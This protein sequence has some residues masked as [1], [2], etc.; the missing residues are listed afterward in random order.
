MSLQRPIALCVILSCLLCPEPFSR[1]LAADEAET[2]KTAP[3]PNDAPPPDRIEELKK[4]ADEL[5]DAIEQQEETIERLSEAHD[6]IANVRNEFESIQV[7]RENAD[8]T[9][10]RAVQ[11]LRKSRA[12]QTEDDEA[13]EALRTRTEEDYQKAKIRL[14]L[15]EISLWQHVEELRAHKKRLQDEEI[16]IRERESVLQAL[17]KTIHILKEFL[18]DEPERKLPCSKE[19]AKPEDKKDKEPEQEETEQEDTSSSLESE[20]FVNHLAQGAE[21]LRRQVD[22]FF[23][24][25]LVTVIPEAE[26]LGHFSRQAMGDGNDS[27][28]FNGSECVLDYRFDHPARFPL[29]TYGFNGEHLERP[30]LLIYEG[31][32]LA[33]RPDGRYQVRFTAGTPPMPVAFQ[34]QFQLLDQCTGQPYTLTLPPITLPT[35]SK[36]AISTVSHPPR[37]V[38]K[39][40]QT[41]H[42]EGYLPIL[43]NMYDFANVAVIRRTG[44]ARFGYGVRVP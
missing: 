9:R 16:L 37:A 12:S 38:F 6:F 41:I 40:L 7:A 2:A 10:D 24:Q 13:F 20:S 14:E 22:P 15:E 31:M 1:F 26:H 32:R 36:H 27:G 21:F 23:L 18:G 43:E 28:D 42:H 19:K 17:K 35:E 34:L 5:K 44:H 33:I 11:A 25:P 29:P 8:H 30:G 3:K 4:V 39:D